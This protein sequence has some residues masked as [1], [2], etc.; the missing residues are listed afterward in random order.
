MMYTKGILVIWKKKEIYLFY[1]NVKVDLHFTQ[2]CRKTL[3]VYYWNFKSTEYD[4]KFWHLVRPFK[5]E[6]ISR[7]F[8]VDFYCRAKIHTF[9]TGWPLSG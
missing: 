5:P 7:K 9:T 1:V 2:F 3:E 8:G 4:S 6:N